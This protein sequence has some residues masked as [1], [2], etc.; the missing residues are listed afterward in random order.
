VERESLTVMIRRL[1]IADRDITRNAV[2]GRLRA[3][4]YAR[5]KRSV[6]ATTCND[7]KATISAMIATGWLPPANAE[8][9]G[10]VTAC[11]LVFH[12]KERGNWR[13]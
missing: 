8:E 10:L 4:G 1:I 11:E 12:S 6:I 5:V 2:V 13:N 3:A 7:T 9:A